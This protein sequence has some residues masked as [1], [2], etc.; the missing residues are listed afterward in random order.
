[1]AR[2]AEF[3]AVLI[4]A[5]KWLESN[6]IGLALM[7]AAY[8]IAF[9]NLWRHTGMMA[10]GTWYGAIEN[11]KFVETWA[12]WWLALVSLPVFQFFLLRWY[13]RLLTWW[14]MLAEISRM[15]LNLQPLHSDRVGGLGFLDDV[16]LAFAPFLLAQG[17]V[18]AGR[19]AERIVFG[20]A[21]LL[22]FKFELAAVILVLVLL[23]LGPLLM[24]GTRLA[25]AK[26][27]T[28]QDF[29]DLA[30]RY[31]RDFNRKW[32]DGGGQTDEAELGTGDIQS[33]ADLGTSF[34]NVQD[35]QLV[36]VQLRTALALAAAIALPM[37]PLLFTMFSPAELLER[38]VQL[39]V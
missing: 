19:V 37:V 12:G 8:A 17:A 38:V 3:E 15:D 33:L 20:G 27:Q 5:R 7:V 28:L 14:R 18:A 30:M 23:V 39:L 2:R 25:S 22:S 26:R 11:G 6:W 24:F 10:T 31:A 16:T 32:L 21:Q 4:A 29:G 36:P 1:M 34:G 35:M 13:V 9:T